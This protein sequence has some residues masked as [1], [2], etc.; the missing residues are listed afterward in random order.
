MVWFSLIF[1]FLLGCVLAVIVATGT[2]VVRGK[3]ALAAVI[4]GGSI[5]FAF[6]A[7]ALLSLFFVGVYSPGVVSESATSITSVGNAQ[8]PQVVFT[9]VQPATAPP[10]ASS[11]V[12]HIRLFPGVI[13]LVIVGFI[14]ARSAKHH[15]AHAGAAHTRAWPIAI[16][17]AIAAFLVYHGFRYQTEVS[18]PQ[19]IHSEAVDVNAQAAVQQ[20]AEMAAKYRAQAEVLTKQ[21]QELSKRVAAL[22]KSIEQRID[23]TDINQLMEEFN[24]PRIVLDGPFASISSPAALLVAAAPTAFDTFE[25]SRSAESSNSAEQ[26]SEQTTET[27]HAASKKKSNA[28]H[29]GWASTKKKDAP[30][31]PEPPSAPA[32][33]AV[34]PV[35]ELP[36]DLAPPAVAEAPADEPFDPHKHEVI[37]A[38]DSFQHSSPAANKPAWTNNPPKRTG[39]VRREVIFT[40]EYATSKECYRAI[41]VILMLKAYDRLQEIEGK[42][43]PFTTGSDSDLPAISFSGKNIL[44]GGDVVSDGSHWT[45]DRLKL[46][47]EMK[48]DPEFLRR[49]IVAK[50]SKKNETCEYLEKTLRSVGPMNKLYYQIEFTPAIDRILT[51]HHDAFERR[52]RFAGV[53]FGAFSI[54]GLLSIAWGLLKA[55]TA[56]KGYYSKWLFV[57]GPIAII[58]T[59]TLS[60]FLF[61]KLGLHW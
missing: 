28:K 27:D 8:A 38:N 50:D 55:D 2:A 33:T 9:G 37:S 30:A 58:G 41:E 17:I 25:K 36:A 43:M 31:A 44:L 23:N 42:P 11:S 56:T 54:F 59:A 7:A 1:L 20:A 49:E 6:V 14:L 24:A 51:Q 3:F 4:A 40:D 10:F 29:N 5:V 48:I 34:P 47:S 53:G 12:W 16:A 15:F 45:D 18:Y 57:G 13:I 39:D 32:P 22:S 60:L 46:M 61:M 52:Q 26:S 19:V 21:Q 35:A